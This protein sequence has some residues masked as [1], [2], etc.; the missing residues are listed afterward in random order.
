MWGGQCLGIGYG[1]DGG[2]YEVLTGQCEDFGYLIGDYNGDMQVNILDIIEIIDL[3]IDAEYSSVADT[4]NDGELNVI[5]IIQI[6][7]III[8]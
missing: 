1:C 6:V 3:I 7:D 8:N 5:D 4:N 2:T